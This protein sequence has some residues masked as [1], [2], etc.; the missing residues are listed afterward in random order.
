[1]RHIHTM[2]RHHFSRRK[3]SYQRGVLG[4]L[5]CLVLVVG[6]FITTRGASPHTSELAFIEKSIGNIGSVIP[7]SCESAYE[8]TPGECTAPTAT[9]SASPTS[10]A[11]NG[12]STLTWSSTGATSCTAG[13]PWSNSGTLSGSGLTNPLTSNTT[14]TFYCTGP[15]GTSPTQ[16]VTVSAASTCPNGYA[17]INSSCVACGNG[18]CT[19]A[20][21]SASNPLGSLVC[22][23]GA[24][25]PQFC[26]T[27]TPT[28]SLSASPTVI[29]QGQSSI[30]S[31][32][33][34]NA[35]SCTGTGFTAGGSSG[36]RSTGILNNPGTSN[37][38]VVCTGAGGTSAPAFA[39][40]EVLSP[41]VTISASPTR[42]QAGAN[43]QI[44]WSASGVKSCTVTGPS[45]TLASGN[46]N[47]S[48]NFSIGSPRSVSISTQSI[49]T[50]TCQTNGTPATKSVTV[51]VVAIFQ[52]F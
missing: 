47:A 21:G 22:I 25:N 48:H 1:M 44:S 31:W 45:G 11:Y 46:A 23:N 24:N 26:S 19:G 49:F 34:T 28:A 36:T 15:G 2:V 52:E 30:L 27:F 42:V 32:S 41:N 35:T 10:V 50:I 43:S 40:V 8:H 29:D 12:R 9:L 17:Y 5:A 39:S 20:G 16:S 7:A 51:N 13:G 3:A 18:G 6:L 14:F 4:A 38:Q 33:S 37:Y